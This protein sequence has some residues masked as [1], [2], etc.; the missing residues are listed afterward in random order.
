M[1]PSDLSKPDQFVHMGKPPVRIDVLTSIAGGDFEDVYKKR[2]SATIDGVLLPL[3]CK[4]HLIQNKLATGRSKDVTDAELL[5]KRGRNR[6]M[7]KPK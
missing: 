5:Q 4:D 2:I 3:I 6:R 7:K 1:K